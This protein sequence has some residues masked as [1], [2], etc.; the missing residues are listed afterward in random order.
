[1]KIDIYFYRNKVEKRGNW[2]I[3]SDFKRL[4]YI[5]V[6]NRFFYYF[7]IFIIIE[8]NIINFGI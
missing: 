5:I 8:W 6:F 3:I 2:K 1:M 4:G 7:V